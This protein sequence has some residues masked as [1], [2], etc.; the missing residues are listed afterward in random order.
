V[1]LLRGRPGAWL[2]PE[3]SSKALAGTLI[4]A[5]DAIRPGE[6]F[7]H[8]FFPSSAQMGSRETQVPEPQAPALLQK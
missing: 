3:I 5:L 2:A 1:D 4:A 6:R 8:A 7:C